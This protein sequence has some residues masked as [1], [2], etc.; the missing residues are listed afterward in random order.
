MQKSI[1][2]TVRFSDGIVPG[3]DLSEN[4]PKTSFPKDHQDSQ[5]SDFESKIK[6]IKM[7]TKGKLKITNS[8]Y[9]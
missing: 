6:K 2:K 9:K 8:K 4:D 5:D 1:V 3:C 7:K